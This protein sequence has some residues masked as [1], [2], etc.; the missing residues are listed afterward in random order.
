MAESYILFV[1][2]VE[3]EFSA[4]KNQT[5]PADMSQNNETVTEPQTADQE[6]TSIKQSDGNNNSTSVTVLPRKDNEQQA[7]CKINDDAEDTKPSMEAKNKDVQKQLGSVSKMK[8]KSNTSLSKIGEKS[9]TP[10][11]SFRKTIFNTSKSPPDRFKTVKSHDCVKK[12]ESLKYETKNTTPKSSTEK[13]NCETESSKT[14]DA[15]S[16]NMDKAVPKQ[17][18]HVVSK[19]FMSKLKG[20]ESHR[21]NA[22]T[23]KQAVDKNKQEATT[24]FKKEEEATQSKIADL[25]SSGSETKEGKTVGEKTYQ[26]NR[27]A[28]G[29]GNMRRG[30][31]FVSYKNSYLRVSQGKDM[32]RNTDETAA[33]YRRSSLPYTPNNPRVDR[34][35][36]GNAQRRAIVKKE[37]TNESYKSNSRIEDRSANNVESCKKQQNEACDQSNRIKLESKNS[38]SSNEHR[39]DAS[40]VEPAKVKTDLKEH[41]SINNENTKQVTASEQR[42]KVVDKS[43]VVDKTQQDVNNEMKNK[44]TNSPRKAQVNKEI[45]SEETNSLKQSVNSHPN[46]FAVESQGGVR[47]EQPISKVGNAEYVKDA[48][49]F[50]GKPTWN[51]QTYDNT[52]QRTIAMNVQQS[53]QNMQYSLQQERNQMRSLYQPSP[54]DSSCDKVQQFPNNNVRYSQL[55][56]TAFDTTQYE[57]NGMQAALCDDGAVNAQSMLMPMMG[58]NVEQDPNMMYRYEPSLQQ[59]P[60][61]ASS[62]FSGLQMDEASRWS[63]S[64]HNRHLYVQVDQSYNSVPAQHTYNSTSSEQSYNSTPEHSMHVYNTDFNGMYTTQATNCMPHSMIYTPTPCMQ[65]WN[66][67]LQYS[68]PVFYASPCAN[69]A[70]VPATVNQLSNFDNIGP[71]HDQFK[72]VPYSRTNNYAKNAHDDVNNCAV[73][74]RNN[75]ADKSNQYYKQC[76]DNCRFVY[77]TPPPMSHSRSQDTNCTSA[78]LGATHQCNAY[79]S[80]NQRYHRQNT[81]NLR[82]QMQDLGCDDKDSEDI[83]PIISPKEF[84]TRS[85]FAPR[86]YNQDQFRNVGCHTPQLQKYN[87]G[88]LRRNASLHNFS[89]EYTSSV[90]IGRGRNKR[91]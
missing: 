9:S 44:E 47:N 91:V 74:M 32:P 86:T 27:K 75:T 83:P 22:P 18:Q 90:S 57:Y 43:E 71:A 53:V 36:S 89:R 49:Q 59:R 76:H 41:D 25:P 10:S 42:E 39:V 29:G 46:K 62:N 6:V 3:A 63:P 72:Y 79:R 88:G 23:V 55:P 61:T 1:R 15:Q 20:Q 28:T 37:Y 84:V 64:V 16:K 26:N 21:K 66:P 78:T 51:G 77:D 40:N 17:Q 4:D 56:N 30:T 19:Q 82:K 58:V 35:N 67:Q 45:K 34:F 68:I 38:E 8:N 65:P 13:K 2:F 14:A 87:G 12:Q 52:I 70:M 11:T 33:T 7:P 60:V 73:Q 5:D 54:W 85:E 69:Y 24:P 81:T 50:V 48:S 31:T 80:T